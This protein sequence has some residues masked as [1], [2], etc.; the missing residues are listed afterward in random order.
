MV[1]TVCPGDNLTVSCSTNSSALQ[2]R[3]NISLTP[4]HFNEGEDGTRLITT[5]P[6]TEHPIIINQTVFYFSKISSSPLV[7]VVTVDNVTT[8]M[9]LTKIVCFNPRGMS[10]TIIHIIDY[11]KIIISVHYYYSVLKTKRT[12]R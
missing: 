8:I 2:W 4:L 12:L 10:S 5:G 6:D 7:S 9:N 1:S 11:G 3:V